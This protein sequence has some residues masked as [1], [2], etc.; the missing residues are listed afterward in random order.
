MVHGRLYGPAALPSSLNAVV[1]ACRSGLPVIGAGGVYRPAD[2]EAM[3]AAG[4]A[5]VQ[6]DAVLWR[7]DFENLFG[8]AVSA[9][10]R[11]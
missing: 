10:A 3:F 6:L 2:L 11:S 4:A 8:D 5:A 9:R 1:E 7:G